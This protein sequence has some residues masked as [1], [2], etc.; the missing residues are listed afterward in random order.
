MVKVKG[1]SWQDPLF[2]APSP[3]PRTTSRASS[4]YPPHE[5]LRPAPK[6]MRCSNALLL[7]AG[8]VAV[9]ARAR[10]PAKAAIEIVR[11][12]RVRPAG[13]RGVAELGRKGCCR[14][15]RCIADQNAG[16]ASVLTRGRSELLLLA[17]R[18]HS[19]AVRELRSAG[20]G[21]WDVRLRGRCSRLATDSAEE[22]MQGVRGESVRSKSC[23]TC[24]ESWWRT[25][26]SSRHP[27]AVR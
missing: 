1:I 20:R 22:Q 23:V 18:W 3:H 7:A 10:L 11:S 9:A 21:R 4:S 14:A 16:C 19:H 26:R 24:G 25:V 5:P 15:L 12:A 13:G 17:V 2:L 6:C 27:C 8:R